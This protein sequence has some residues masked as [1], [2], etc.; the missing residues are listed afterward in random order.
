[1]NIPTS[2]PITI[3]P[4]AAERT[5]EL[6]RERELEQIIEH[7][8]RT[9]PNLLSID[10]EL[11]EPYDAGDTQRVVVNVWI[12]EPLKVEDERTGDELGDWQVRTFP[13]EVN[14]NFLLFVAYGAPHGR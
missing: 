10:V 11:V 9:V 3:S 5:R 7:V 6:A 8:C 12:P 14:W 4:E 13:P 2:V 1:M